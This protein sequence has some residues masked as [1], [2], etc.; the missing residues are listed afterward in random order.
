V[1]EPSP[2]PPVTASFDGLK[3]PARIDAIRALVEATG[4]VVVDPR[5]HEH[6]AAL[7]SLRA[8]PDSPATLSGEDVYRSYVSLD[9]KSKP[10][11]V[12]Y[13][14]KW[15]GGK[16]ASCKLSVGDLLTLRFHGTNQTA[17]TEFSG[18]SGSTIQLNS[19]TFDRAATPPPPGSDDVEGFAC[20]I[21]TIAHEWTHTI[22]APDAPTTERFL[23]RGHDKASG[24]LVSYT[25][26]AIAQC[27]YLESIGHLS[28]PFA[29]CI[30]QA[31]T[32]ILK[33][34]PCQRGWSK[35]AMARH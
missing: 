32:N 7:S 6:L 33:T 15:V 23:D 20:A 35:G 24:M 12:S 27:T 16:I 34:A 25:V 2:Q 30:D 18:A 22:P 8:T 11:A 26:G 5:F 21:N 29:T 3:T 9:P 1:A 14:P 19:C 31:G 28:I 10:G 13:E 17:D 4:K